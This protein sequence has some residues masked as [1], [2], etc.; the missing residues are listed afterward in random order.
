MAVED[1]LFEIVKSVGAI[2]GLVTGGFVVFDRMFRHRPYLSF[3]P[4]GVTQSSIDLLFH[5]AADEGLTIERVKVVPSVFSVAF[6]DDLRSTVEAAATPQ[7]GDD[8]T[9]FVRSNSVVALPLITF[10]EWDSASNNLKVVITV[11][12]RSCSSRHLWNRPISITRTVGE[13]KR[14]E[15]SAKPDPIA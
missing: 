3:R 4:R 14:L 1:G 9:A 15:K 13:I 7:Y 6:G 8:R 5:N 11:K 10:S 2:V 12:W